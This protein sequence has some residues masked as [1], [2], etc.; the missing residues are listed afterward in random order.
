MIDRIVSEEVRKKAADRFREQG[1]ILPTFAQMKN[2]DLIPGKIKDK[3]KNIG[4]WDLHP[5]N[6]FRITWKN[7]PKKSGGLYGDVNYIELPSQLTGVDARIVLLIGKYFP[8]GAHKVG[9]AYG[10]LAPRIITGTF[11]PTYHKAVWP[12]TGNYC[13]GGAFDS[14]LMATTAV[15]ILPE[16][17]SQERFSWLEEIGAEVIA[18]PGCESNVKEIY[19]KCWDIR[20]TR[21]DCVIFNQFDEFGN[22]AW[23]YSITGHAIDEVYNQIKT[24]KSNFAAYVSATG[25][26]GTIAAGDYLRTLYPHIK[27]T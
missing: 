22:S 20:R 9:A 6:L 18:T 27:V 8:T 4:L 21:K 26:A 5:L 11:D 23:H 13:R 14:Y 17:M 3:L 24:E 1:I 7:E 2:P 16:E 19:D 12:S 25:S 10:C 15:A